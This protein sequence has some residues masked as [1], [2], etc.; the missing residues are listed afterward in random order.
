[1]YSVVMSIAKLEEPP[2]NDEQMMTKLRLQ[3]ELCTSIFSQPE[4]LWERETADLHRQD[5]TVLHIAC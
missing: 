1:M 3:P 5:L 2:K 4:H